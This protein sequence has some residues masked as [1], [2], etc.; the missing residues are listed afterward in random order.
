MLFTILVS[1]AASAAAPLPPPPPRAHRCMP[2]AVTY[3]NK[4]RRATPP[5]K[6]GDLPTAPRKLGELPPATEYLAVVR[7]VGGCPEP[8]VV[9]SGIGVR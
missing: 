1:L 3:A 8:A 6:L 7:N 4:G 5:Q 9:R 2:P